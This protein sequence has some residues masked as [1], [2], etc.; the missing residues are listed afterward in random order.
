[1]PVRTAPLPFDARR[2][3]VRRL[4]LRAGE[5]RSY[6]PP[7]KEAS[8]RTQHGFTLIEVMITLAIIAILTAIA[9]PQYSEYVMR[10]RITEAVM[11]LS[12]QRLKMERFFQDNRSYTPAVGPAACS[13]NTVAPLPAPTGHFSYGCVVGPTAYTVT[14]TGNGSM[15]GFTFTVDETNVKRTT[16]VPTGWTASPN[17]WVL[18]KDGS[19]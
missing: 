1:M 16:L 8:M 19:C 14:A 4:P 5:G 15:A 3:P 12:D 6:T 18:K 17:C 2:R 11:T 13:P 10:S 7:T 9:I